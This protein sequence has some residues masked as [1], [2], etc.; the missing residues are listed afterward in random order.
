MPAEPTPDVRVIAAFH[1]QQAAEKLV[2]AVRLSRGLHA[3]ADHN[4]PVLV[5]E[6]KSDD[7]WK[8]ELEGLG[9]LSAYATAY[10]YPSPGGRRSAGPPADE[11][12]TWLT[13]LS[14]LLTRICRALTPTP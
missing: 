2:K 6:L 7:E 13:K 8:A 5:G 3:T 4:I 11:V 12:K 10:R 1:L 14:S 9:A